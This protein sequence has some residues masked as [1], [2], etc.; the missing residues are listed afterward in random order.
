MK[1]LRFVTAGDLLIIMVLLTCSAAVF[2]FGRDSY[3]GARHVVV[4]VS[5]KNVLE[6]PLEANAV[7]TVAGPVGNT[8]VE[9]ENGRVRVLDSDCPN[10]TCI[11][12]GAID[13]PG[14]VIV[15]VPNQVMVTIRGSGSDREFDGVTQ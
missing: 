9:I 14:E 3:A 1:R 4:A 10:H 2:A 6:L 8:T 11:Q 12:M 5:G 7:R 13:H 15:C